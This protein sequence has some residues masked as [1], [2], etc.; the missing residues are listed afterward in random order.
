[1]KNISKKDAMAQAKGESSIYKRDGA[2]FV[3][4]QG[5]EHGPTDYYRAKSSRLAWCH[6]R[7]AELRGWGTDSRP[8]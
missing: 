4:I 3:Q 6:A 7:V 1:M 5:V 2:W 8:R